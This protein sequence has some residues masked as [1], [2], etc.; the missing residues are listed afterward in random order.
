MLIVPTPRCLALDNYCNLSYLT[1]LFGRD[2]YA[3]FCKNLNV[4][5]SLK[6]LKQTKVVTAKSLPRS[7]SE[8]DRNTPQRVE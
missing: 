7:V 4:V 2:S 6:V 1:E 8:A 5:S 3:T